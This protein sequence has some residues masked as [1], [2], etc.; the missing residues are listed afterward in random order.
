MD[1]KAAFDS[2]DRMKLVEA[3][4]RRG[5]DGKLV[6]RCKEVLRESSFR[7]KV[8]EEMGKEFLTRRGVKQGCPL[9][10][11]LF[12]LFIADLEEELKKGD[13]EE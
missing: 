2:V 7:V 9:S 8:G 6:R 3:L 13:G 1:L 12:S 4:A 5:V 10:P 11:S